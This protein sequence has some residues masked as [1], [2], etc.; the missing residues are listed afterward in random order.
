M[1]SSGLLLLCK[2][3]EVF[4]IPRTFQKFILSLIFTFYYEYLKKNILIQELKTVLYLKYNCIN[5][6]VVV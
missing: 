5:G 1:N 3:P 4:M 2:R 6:L